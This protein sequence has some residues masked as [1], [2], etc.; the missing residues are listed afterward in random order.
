M[1]KRQINHHRYC[2][3]GSLLMFSFALLYSEKVNAFSITKVGIDKTKVLGHR[4]TV[5]IR[6]RICLSQEERASTQFVKVKYWFSNTPTRKKLSLIHELPARIVGKHCKILSTSL[7]LPSQVER[8][9]RY[10]FISYEHEKRVC[11]QMKRIR[12]T[13]QPRLKVFSLQLLANSKEY[14]SSKLTLHFWIRNIGR[15]KFKGAVS[16]EFYLFDKLTKTRRKLKLYSIKLP[17]INAGSSYPS[18]TQ[19]I[20]VVKLSAKALESTHELQAKMVQISEKPFKT[21]AQ[22]R[23]S[24]PTKS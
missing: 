19:G 15:T 14:S 13:G 10:I 23:K 16:A 11:W 3:F 20:A 18:S 22:R 8:G 17:N 7:M 6:S 21:Q 4:S 9:K 1:K 12:I 2:I 24:R 5:T